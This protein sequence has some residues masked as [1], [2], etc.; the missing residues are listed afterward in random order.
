[1]LA[2]NLFEQLV[3]ILGPGGFFIAGVVGIGIMADSSRG[4]TPAL[5]GEFLLLLA[6][7]IVLSALYL[8]L[9][10]SLAL[11]YPCAVL[12]NISWF[13]AVRRSW[14]LSRG[15]RGR[16]I[17]VWM[18]LFSTSLFVNHTL[19]FC[20]HILLHKLPHI[21]TTW[22]GFPLYLCWYSLATAWA[23]ALIGPIYPIALTLFYYDQRIRHEG[24]D[25]ERMMDAAGLNA[26]ANSASGEA[27]HVPAG[28][29]ED[30][31]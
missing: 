11:S 30:Q 21:W 20:V 22:H 5:F 24:Y 10:S 14:W 9:A 3:F 31:P 28:A 27:S 1:M 2:L 18:L 12:E 25:I 19:R 13:V 16:I 7:I 17:A 23:A 6:L 26:P 15:S 29:V 8:F 4:K